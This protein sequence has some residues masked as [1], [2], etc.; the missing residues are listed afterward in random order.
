MAVQFL[1]RLFNQISGSERMSEDA[2]RIVAATEESSEV[3]IEQ[4][5][6]E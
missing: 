5:K 2:H 1:T 3:I 4:W 6:L